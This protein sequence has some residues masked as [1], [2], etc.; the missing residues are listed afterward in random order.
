M[1]EVTVVPIIT[2]REL[3]EGNRVVIRDKAGRVEC[4][5][6]RVHLLGDPEG[7]MRELVEGMSIVASGYTRTNLR[8]VS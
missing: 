7:V 2:D 5:V 3:P 8:A 4:F 1:P 6:N